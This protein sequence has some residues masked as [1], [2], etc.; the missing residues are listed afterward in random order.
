MTLHP[1]HH[2]IVLVALAAA[3]VNA[4][5]L[6]KTDPSHL[7]RKVDTALA[8]G[9]TAQAME[10]LDG[11]VHSTHAPAERYAQSG[12]LY[13][14]LGT[15]TGRLRSQRV[16]ELGLR[17]YPERPDLW[18]ELGETYYEQTFY[19]DAR[20]CFRRVLELD[21]ANCEA[22]FYLGLDWFRRWKYIQV[23]TEY[24]ASA[25]PYFEHVARCEPRNR[26][27]AYR[28]ALSTYA[29]GDTLRATT[30]IE[31]FLATFPSV[32]AGQLLRGTIAFQQSDYAL[33]DSLFAA[34]RSLMSEEEANALVDISLLLPEDDV[35]D[36]TWGSEKKR[37]NVER[38]FWAECDPDPTTPLNE[39][40]MEHVQRMFL[41]DAFFDNERP[42]LRGWE[43][44]RGKALVKFGWP[45]GVNTTLA[46]DALSGPMEVWVYSNAFVGLTLFFRDEFLNG[47]YMVPMDYRYASVAQTLYL[48]PPASYYVSPYWQ[49]PGV[50]E[51]ISFRDALA[52]VNVYVALRIDLAT[53]QD[54]VDLDDATRFFLRLSF[55][56]TDW[57]PQTSYVDTIAGPSM[58]RNRDGDDACVIVREFDLGFDSLRVASCLEDELSRTQSLSND[59]TSTRRYLS[60][61]LVLSDI[62]LYRPPLAGDTSN[63]IRR[64]GRTFVPNPGGLYAGAEHLRLYVE[65][66]NLDVTESHS[67]YQ[68]TYSIY[69]AG[70]GPQ[71][72]GQI[73]H[74]LK[75]MIGLG[76]QDEAV[77]SH[78]FDRR[79]AHHIGEESLAIDIDALRP[80]EYTLRISV[81][82]RR[83]GEVATQGRT[84]SK[85]N[86]A[87]TKPAAAAP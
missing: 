14:S 41:A 86:G 79:G 32:A 39:K 40:Y 5:T 35:R 70:D 8:Q 19:G 81:T 72:W 45:D 53:L 38:V 29:L 60:E 52:A 61:T 74:S 18:L 10:L 13:R 6:F 87:E 82:D 25:V 20:R 23:Y 27:A 24:L 30:L 84:F 59:R 34:A 51:V 26:V 28:L 48:D 85:V 44:E 43:T 76:R 62:L 36:Y 42:R 49:I 78:T 73:A 31:A 83:S 55:F 54:Y 7:A 67:D 69:E 65:I 64:G 17:Y 66:Y 12:A 80:G 57:R 2:R 4:C 46:G 3:A 71:G 56:D 77:I 50:M 47:N 33:C 68:I 63:V 75:R 9:D 11:V 21:A 16:L 37:E 58:Q 1:P 22:H 15:I